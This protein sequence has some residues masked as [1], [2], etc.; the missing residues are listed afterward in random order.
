MQNTNLYY[1]YRSTRGNVA[2]GLISLIVLLFVLIVFGSLAGCPQYKIYHQRLEGEAEL[3]KAEYS[4]KV[5]V[6]EALAKEDAAI[7]LANAEVARANGV[8]KA[9]NIIGN[10]LKDNEAYLRYL[11]IQALQDKNHEVIY[12]PTEAGLPILESNRLRK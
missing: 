7:H 11:Y 3:A 2:T 1:P 4:K 9:N 8:A 5:A 6:Q 10:S 12:V